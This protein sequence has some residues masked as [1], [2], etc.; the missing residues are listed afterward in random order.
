MFNEN[1]INKEENTYINNELLNP[2]ENH[3]EEPCSL[4]HHFDGFFMCYTLKNQFVHYYRYGQR[5][6]CSS[7]WRDLLWCIRSKSQSKEMEQK[8]LHEKRLE[9]LEKLKKGRN[10]EEIWS[11]K[12]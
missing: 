5:P 6:D 2:I 1:I 7:K 3:E 9:R 11:L 4:Q 10:S 8:M 12:T